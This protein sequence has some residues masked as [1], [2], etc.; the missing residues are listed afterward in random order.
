L[1]ADLGQCLLFGVGQEQTPLDLFPQNA[2]FGSQVL[3]AQQQFLVYRPR[4]VG[5][6]TRPIHKISQS[7][8]VIRQGLG[9]YGSPG[10]HTKTCSIYTATEKPGVFKRFEFFGHTG[11]TRQHA[12]RQSPYEALTLSQ[13]YLTLARLSAA[14]LHGWVLGADLSHDLRDHWFAYHEPFHKVPNFY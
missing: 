2:V 13:K 12:I 7:I 1:K 9:L 8:I 3:I 6:D 10:H 5:Q 14:Y 11:L 4:D